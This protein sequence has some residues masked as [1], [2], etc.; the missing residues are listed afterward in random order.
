V[1]VTHP[2]RI[3]PHRPRR[4]RAQRWGIGRERGVMRIVMAGGGGFLGGH[5]LPALRHAGHTVIRLVRRAPR[6]PAEAA[7][8]PDTGVL[9]ASALSGADAIINLCGAGVGDRRWTADR[10]D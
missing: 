3:R 1:S 6:N 9:P 2:G 10:R 4:P 8:N 5:L 7:W